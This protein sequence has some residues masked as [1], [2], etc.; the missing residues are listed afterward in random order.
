[1]KKKEYQSELTKKVNR[2]LYKL[3]ENLKKAYKK[4]KIM[5]T[6]YQ[7]IIFK[8]TNKIEI[9]EIKEDSLFLTLKKY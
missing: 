8:V 7:K 9:E 3:K 1:M 4:V 5:Q 2:E 6:D